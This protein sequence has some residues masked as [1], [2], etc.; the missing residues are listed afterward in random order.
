MTT[1][2]RDERESKQ[3]GQF[4]VRVSCSLRVRNF[5]L[6]S[7]RK[8][9]AWHLRVLWMCGRTPPPAMVARTRESNSSSPRI[10]S[11]RW[12]GVIRLTRR[13]LEAFPA[14]VE[15][16]RWL[17]E[18]SRSGKKSERSQNLISIEWA[19]SSQPHELAELLPKSLFIL[20]RLPLVPSLIVRHISNPKPSSSKLDVYSP[21]NSRTSA[22]KYS[23]IALAYTAAL[24]PIRTWFWVRDLRKRWIRP[25]GNWE[26]EG[27]ANWGRKEIKSGKAKIVSIP[28]RL[29]FRS[30]V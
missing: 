18:S 15:V 3:K 17:R 1:R 28:E 6:M 22:V 13:S 20:M 23:R 25:T 7:L 29:L 21:A 30:D 27:E 19:R 2:G 5:F 9:F 26:G 8:A 10:A 4:N 14:W 24:A 12:R 16:W 11:W